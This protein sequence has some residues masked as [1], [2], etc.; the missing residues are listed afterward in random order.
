MNGKHPPWYIYLWVFCGETDLRN[1]HTWEVGWQ[2]SGNNDGCKI[3]C[4]NWSQCVRSQ[5]VRTV[6]STH[7]KSLNIFINKMFMHS[8]FS[9][10][11]LIAIWNAYKDLWT[12]K[13]VCVLV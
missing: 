13:I 2:Y 6:S 8:N 11:D 9:P 4:I 1:K 10:Y 3:V 5:D 7:K 12:H